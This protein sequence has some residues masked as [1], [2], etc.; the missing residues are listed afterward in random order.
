MSKLE[1]PHCGNEGISGLRKMF[2]GPAVPATC[3]VCGE[4]VGVLFAA[5]L[6]VVPALAG[7]GGAALLGAPVLKAVLCVGS[8]VVMSLCHLR[9]VPLVPRY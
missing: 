3:K 2:L 4:K 8:F 9:W 7:I 1:C 5:I 6:A